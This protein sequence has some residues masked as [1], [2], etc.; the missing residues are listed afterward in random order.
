LA[1]HEADAE[2]RRAIAREISSQ[3]H[4]ELEDATPVEQALS[5]DFPDGRGQQQ[6][7]PDRIDFLPHPWP[8]YGT[9]ILSQMQR[10]AQ[11]PGKVDYREV[12]ESVFQRDTRDLAQELGFGKQSKPHLEA[13]HPFASQDAFSYMRD[14]PFCAFQ[15]QRRPWKDYGPNESIQVRLGEFCSHLAD[16]A[17]GKMDT[18]LEITSDGEIGHLE[19]MLNEMIL[20]LR[21]S[22][23][24]M[25]EQMAD[26]KTRT[27]ELQNS[28]KVLLSLAEDAEN[29]RKEAEREVA[30]R[31][32]AEQELAKRAEELARS[33]KELEEFAY[34]ASHDLQ[35]PLRMVSSY[36]QLLQRRYQDRLDDDADKFIAYAVDGA[37]RMQRLIT[38]L[39]AYSRVTTRGKAFHPIDCEQVLRDV[40]VN[41]QK[42]IEE[43]GAEVS[44][45]PLPKIIAD[46]AQLVQLFQNLIGNS[47]KYRSEEPPRVHISAGPAEDGWLFCVRDNGMGIEPQYA[48]RIF[49]IFQRLHAKGEYSGT[50]IGLAIC[51]RIVE[52]HGG[53]IWVESEL[54]RGSTF[55]FTIPANKE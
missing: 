9:W 28:E 35:E 32:R 42:A 27:E 19:Q 1:L 21:F 46:Q 8:D 5:G 12:V 17:A 37:T 7:V 6:V 15:E 14:Q 47:I 2:Q 30:E 3:G 13:I 18:P 33:N 50:G 25:S 16:V 11:L 26:L 43:S 4:L 24:A 10:W 22:R 31:E 41:L 40:L 45:D 49:V 52:R 36:T 20:N 39:L 29:A 55:C 44:H 51:K 38:D 54:G 23:E 34:V 53:R 48:D